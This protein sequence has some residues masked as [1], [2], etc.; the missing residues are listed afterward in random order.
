MWW[1]CSVF[2]FSLVY[3]QG[4]HGSTYLLI[5]DLAAGRIRHDRERTDI[6]HM[7]LEMTSKFARRICGGSNVEGK[8]G[9]V[10][11]NMWPR[12]NWCRQIGSTICWQKR[13]WEWLNADT[14]PV[15]EKSK[16]RRTTVARTKKKGSTQEHILLT[17][18]EELY[19]NGM[20]KVGW[21]RIHHLKATTH[22]ITSRTELPYG[23][24]H[25]QQLHRTMVANSKR[26]HTSNLVETWLTRARTIVHVIK[27][28]WAKQTLD[29]RQKK[30]QLYF[31]EQNELFK[32]RT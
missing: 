31:W 20:Y 8:N 14:Q 16:A 28:R 7:H 24:R 25:T 19:N 15:K 30:R 21:E 6:G 18:P 9:D 32:V 29:S 10:F 3:E 23:M 13:W 12:W 4:V 5:F 26:T 1:W 2:F 17:A 11:L 22:F 27:Q